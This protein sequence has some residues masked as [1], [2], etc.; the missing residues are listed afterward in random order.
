MKK[1]DVIALC[2]ISLFTFVFFYTILCNMWE[3]CWYALVTSLF[4]SS[5]P[6]LLLC[7]LFCA[8]G[9]KGDDKCD[10]NQNNIPL[11][12]GQYDLPDGTRMKI[13]YKS[14]D[15]QYYEIWDNWEIIE[16]IHNH[17]DNLTIQEVLDIADKK[18]KQREDTTTNG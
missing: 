2:S 10:E 13:Y 4:L 5:A 16:I 17:I 3:P 1:D 6:L 8:E 9:Y 12:R 14:G 7:S 18:V 15:I 11:D